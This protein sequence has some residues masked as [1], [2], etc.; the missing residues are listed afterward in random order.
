MDQ[1]DFVR[2]LVVIIAAWNLAVWAALRRSFFQTVVSHYGQKIGAETGAQLQPVIFALAVGLIIPVLLAWI[3]FLAIYQVR[4]GAVLS[5][6]MLFAAKLAIISVVAIR[7]RASAKENLGAIVVLGLI[8]TVSLPYVASYIINRDAEVSTVLSSVGDVVIRDIRDVLP[9]IIFA[10]F[11][12][13][14]G[15]FG[16]AFVDWDTPVVMIDNELI[17]LHNKETYEALLWHEV[18]HLVNRDPIHQRWLS[19]GIEVLV[20]S[21]A[22]LTTNRHKAPLSFV[23]ALR[24][25]SLVTAAA[26]T[27]LFV[28]AMHRHFIELRADQ[29]SAARVGSTRVT[30]FLTDSSSLSRLH[31]VGMILY[32]SD[33]RRFERLPE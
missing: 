6:C 1:N 29:Y 13:D 21:L 3:A 5:S 19:F 16:A 11:N 15:V 26:L 4:V 22:F 12:I 23:A 27:G 20:L 28:Y 9:H 8:W 32:P 18:G 14:D 33:K 7:C 24:L 25:T 2:L 30:S 10:K 31:M 17:G